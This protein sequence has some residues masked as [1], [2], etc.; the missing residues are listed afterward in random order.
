MDYWSTQINRLKE[1]SN[2]KLDEMHKA[3]KPFENHPGRFGDFYAH[4]KKEY[5]ERIGRKK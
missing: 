3:F 1:L 2:A 5:A 4:L